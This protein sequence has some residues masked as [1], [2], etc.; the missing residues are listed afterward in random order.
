MS[1]GSSW[2]LLLTDGMTHMQPKETRIPYI[3]HKTHPFDAEPIIIYCG[4][5]LTH[6]KS[7]TEAIHGHKLLQFIIAE[8]FDISHA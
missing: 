5:R 8:G 2:A 1:L 6:F 7:L 3:L 4:Q